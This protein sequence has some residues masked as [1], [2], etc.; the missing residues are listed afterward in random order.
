[1]AGEGVRIFQ[2]GEIL[3]ADQVNGYLMDQVISRFSDAATRDASFGGSGQ[4]VL[5]EGRFCYLDDVNEVQYFDGA[6]WQSAPQFVLA[7]GTVT[8]A[9]LADGAVTSVKIADG[10]ITNSQISTSAAISLSKLAPSSA[11]NVVIY[12]GSGVAAATPV[13][14]DISISSSGVSAI[15]SGVVVN[16]D[17]STSADIDLSKLNVTTVTTIDTQTSNYVLVLSD[18]YKIIETNSGSN[19]TVSVPTNASVGFPNGTQITIVQYGAGKTQIIASSPG[20]TSI[21]ATPG[22]FLRAR[23]SSA[24]LIK[25]ATDEWYLFGDLSSS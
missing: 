24:T 11:G 8:T 16:A 22:Q 20:T 13:S 4:P 21:R 25:R 6:A 2:E 17:I 23:Y 15:N 14:G 9:K 1:V 7:D 12:N 19:N 10:A 5:T 3:R 18:R